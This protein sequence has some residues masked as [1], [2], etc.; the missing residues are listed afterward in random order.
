MAKRKK[1]APTRSDSRLKQVHS[2][3][4]RAKEQYDEAAVHSWEPEQPADCVTKCFYSYGNALSALATMFGL[5]VPQNHY[6]KAALARRFFKEGKIQE[7]IH[8]RLLHL[9]ELRKNVSYGEPGK[10][11]AETDLEDLVT[12]LE[13]FIGEVEDIVEQ[14]RR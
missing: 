8:D 2:Y 10:E 12:E 13:K 11:L 7:D 9:N 14:K 1:A 4:Q 3:L 6:D 5:E